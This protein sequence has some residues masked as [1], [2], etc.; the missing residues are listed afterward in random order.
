MRNFKL[1]ESNS[2]NTKIFSGSQ[3]RLTFF[4]ILYLF[5]S[6][7]VS[8][9]PKFDQ[10]IVDNLSASTTELMQLFAEVSGG[11]KKGDFS[12]REEKY[13]TIV[14]KIEALELQIRARPVPK[15]KVVN[16]VINKSNQRLQQK[17]RG[18][19]ITAGDTAPSATALRNVRKNLETMKSADKEADLT[20]TEVARFKDIVILFLDQ[21][22]T[23]ERH[24]NK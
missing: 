22:L 12:R 7:A 8:L 4:G 20:K 2:K 13:N 17:G 24:L 5:T 19:V 6:C 15:N 9:A 16:K 23:Y 18:S 1:S 10:G 3:F 21:A 11:A 14:G